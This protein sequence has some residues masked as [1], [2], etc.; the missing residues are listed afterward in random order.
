MVSSALGP[1]EIMVLPGAAAQSLRG[2][3]AS[4]VK[5]VSGSLC[6]SDSSTRTPSSLGDRG[7]GLRS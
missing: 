3:G 4:H 6:S 5:A 2:L 7:R 1:K